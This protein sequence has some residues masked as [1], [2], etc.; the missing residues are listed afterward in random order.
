MTGPEWPR[1]NFQSAPPSLDSIAAPSGSSDARDADDDAAAAPAIERFENERRMLFGNFMS[2][3]LRTWWHDPPPWCDA[4]GRPAEPPQTTEGGVPRSWCVYVSKNTDDNG[5]RYA[6]HFGRGAAWRKCFSSDTYVRQRRWYVG[7]VNSAA[8]AAAVAA[9]APLVSSHSSSS[10]G[11]LASAMKRK[12]GFV[13]PVAE[14]E[15][16]PTGHNNAPKGGPIFGLGRTPFHDLYQQ[17]LMRWAYLQRHM[18]HCLDHYERRKNLFLGAT[19]HTANIGWLAIFFLL[20]ISCF[21]PTRALV[22]CWLYSFFWKGRANGKLMRQH[23]DAFIKQLKDEALNKRWLED[24]DSR[25]SSNNWGP[26]TPVDEVIDAG[27]QLL[28]LRDWIRTEFLAGRPIVSL[29]AVQA[30]KTLADLAGLVIWTS[31]HFP[32]SV[33]QSRVWYRSPVGNFLQHVPTDVNLF[34]P[35]TYCPGDT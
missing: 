23:R 2:Q 15:T 4:E 26:C 21:V 35:L 5:W 17:S 16:V 28:P 34:R 33:K 32:R 3:R 31:E 10:I 19:L 25:T 18:E 14:V 29:R 1:F 22:L 9:A 6:T 24:E 12:Q 8:A 13:P 30:C 20:V 7:R 11:S 27:V